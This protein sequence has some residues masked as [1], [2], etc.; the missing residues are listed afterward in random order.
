MRGIFFLDKSGKNMYNIGGK[1]IQIMERLE[2]SAMSAVWSV[3]LSYLIG[4][5]NPAYIAAKIR[6]FDIRKSG[7]GNAGASNAVITMG[8][9]VGAAAA[10]FDIV[11]AYF[12]VRLCVFLFP[13]LRY[14]AELSGTSCIVGHIFP[15]FMGFRGGK[16]LASL[17]GVVLAFSPQLFVLMLLGAIIIAFLTD[18]ICFV[19]IS[20]SIA[21][22]LLYGIM[23]EQLT[24]V[25]IYAVIAVMIP[26]KHISNL[27]RIANGTEAHIS[28]LWKR[29]EEIERLSRH[30]KN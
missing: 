22:P 14:A 28:F 3:L 12:A 25:L 26:C 18:Y 5:V 29:D 7:S 24:G 10:L 6:G 27:R 9:K 20:A 21:F 19:T 11:K 2:G 30:H 4:N 23:T 17:A 13:Q 1:H 16:G 8:K 15:V